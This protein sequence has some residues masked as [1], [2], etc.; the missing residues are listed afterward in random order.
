MIKDLLASGILKPELFMEHPEMINGVVEGFKP[1]L[2]AV[3]TEFIGILSEVAEANKLS[4]IMAKMTRNAYD[5][6]IEAG[7]TK[8]EAFALILRDQNTITAALKS[9]QKGT[10]AK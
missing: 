9:S 7:F 3:G 1:L 4:P 2:R 6:Y 8:E 5:A 10:K